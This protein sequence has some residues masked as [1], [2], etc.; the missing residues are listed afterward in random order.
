MGISGLQEGRSTLH[1][2]LGT[3]DW[4]SRTYIEK[5]VKNRLHLTF[6]DELGLVLAHDSRHLTDG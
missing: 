6:T 1:Q 3:F 4:Q 2:V 5:W